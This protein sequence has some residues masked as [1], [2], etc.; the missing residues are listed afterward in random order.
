MSF[1]FIN[2]LRLI[3]EQSNIFHF[4]IVGAKAVA[5]FLLIFKIFNVFVS[6]TLHTDDGSAGNFAALFNLFAYAFL[7]LSSDWI[8]N[9]IEDTFVVVDNA[10]GTSN[11][12]NTYQFILDRLME[13]Y[14]AIWDGI[15]GAFDTL[16]F[17]I[18]QIPGFLVLI[19][20]IVLAMLCMVADMSLTCG[21]LLTR[22]FMI[23]IMKFVFPMVIALSTLDIAKDLLGRWI[24]KFIGLFILGVLYLGI[25]SFSEII[26]E[27]LLHQFELGLL[28]PDANTDEPG[29]TLYVYTVGGV[30]AI[31]VVFTVKIKL[32]AKATSF[33]ESFFS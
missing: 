21:Y 6:S 3:L 23:E 11:A 7:I 29:S 17:F 16:S 27:T 10:M 15:D 12:P 33:T 22:L 30:I 5:M 4:T 18:T 2:E 14:A 26:A 31:I 24:K 1:D 28:N 8:I 9:V 25:I 20:G 13:K 32:M 19:I